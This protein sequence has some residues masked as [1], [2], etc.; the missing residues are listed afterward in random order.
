M[1]TRRSTIAG[2]LSWAS[3]SATRAE[4]RPRFVTAGPYGFR[5]DG[6]PYA[7]AGT[8]MWYG[9]Y[10]GAD[11]RDRLKRELDRVAELGLTNIRVL[12]ASERS[13]LKHSVSPAFHIPG[14][15]YDQRLLRGLDV[16]LAEMGRRDLKAVIYLTNFWEWSGGMMAYLYWT[17]GRQ[18]LDMNDPAHPW[19]QFPDF[20]ARFYGH[21]PAVAL[22][23]RH[24]RAIVGRINSITGRRYAD[25]PAIMAWQLANEPRPGGSEAAAAANMA[26][27]TG[28]IGRTAALIK[29]LDPHHLVSTGNEGLKGCV[30]QAD[31]VLAAHAPAQVDYLTAHIWPQNWGWLD[32]HDIAGRHEA[33]L[34]KTRDYIALHIDFA[35][36]MGKPLVI[37]EFGYPR[38]GALYEPASPTSFRDRFYGEIQSA[39]LASVDAGG[40]LAGSNFWAWAGEGRAAHPDH[41][42][43]PGDGAWLGDPPHEPQGW[44]S[45]FDVDESTKALIRAHAAAVRTTAAAQARA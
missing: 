26:A 1:L 32:P 31:C 43:R 30:E 36:R 29:Q 12:G 33:A 5:L 3:A 23:E 9:A 13:P 6:R 40:P 39:V 45:V 25:D 38:D 8:N 18:Y 22:Y 35:R 2:G 20:T 27:F 34:A 21:A 15:A 42:F 37:E 41:Q 19:P 17:D 4:A 11:D 44:Y 16:L 24:V 10:A 28:W 14:R 7:F